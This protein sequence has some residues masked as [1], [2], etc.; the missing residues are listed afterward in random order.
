MRPPSLSWTMWN[1]TSLG[2]VAENSFTGTFTRPKLIDPLQ[3][4]R[5]MARSS[6]FEVRTG[7]RRGNKIA[8]SDGR[9]AERLPGAAAPEVRL[10]A[11]TR[12]AT[13]RLAPERRQPPGLLVP[14]VRKL[15]RSDF[16]LILREARRHEHDEQHRDGPTRPGPH[17]GIFLRH[18]GAVREPFASLSTEGDAGHRDEHDNRAENGDDDR[19]RL[20]LPERPRFLHVV[21]EIQRGAN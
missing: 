7:A 10:C 20:G 18:S 16:A 9:A 15:F 5:G 21:G 12:S 14:V 2:E 8:A 4:G 17:D 3:I 6:A 13:P 19:H 1:R 11:Y